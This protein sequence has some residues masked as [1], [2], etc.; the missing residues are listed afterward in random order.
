MGK[1]KEEKI[2]EVQTSIGT[3]LPVEWSWV[4]NHLVLPY[5]QR[6]VNILENP[7]FE[8]ETWYPIPMGHRNDSTVARPKGTTKVLFIGD[9]RYD[10][11]CFLN[12]AMNLLHVSG[13]FPLVE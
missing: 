11:M 3:V 12:N 9:K 7:N 8:F 1:V 6:T 13:D 4:H 2:G 10:K 5:P